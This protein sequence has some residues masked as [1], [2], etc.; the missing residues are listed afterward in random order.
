MA[1]INLNINKVGRELDS[2]LKR[3]MT[4]A[5]ILLEKEIKQSV[6]RDNIGGDNPSLPGEP[7]KKRTG[8][9]LNSIGWSVVKKGQGVSGTVGVLRGS[10]ANQ[11]GIALEYGTSKMAARPF[12]RPMVFKNQSTILRLLING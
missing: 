6:N 12:V 5:V 9:L 8:Q 10:P 3:G 4:K 2:H 1:K 7:P 11:Y